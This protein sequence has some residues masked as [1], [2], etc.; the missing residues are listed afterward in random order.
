MSDVDYSAM[1]D[2][3]LRCYFLEHREDQ[4]AFYAYMDRRYANPNRQVFAIDDPAWQDKILA[5]IK[6]QSPPQ[7]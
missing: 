6:A 7:K 2:Q 5:I 3:E 1:T 4:A